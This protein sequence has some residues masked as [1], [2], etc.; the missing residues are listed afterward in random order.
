[1]RQKPRRNR[2]K[3]YITIAPAVKKRTKA[4]ANTLGISASRLIEDSLKFYME[5][6]FGV[7]SDPTA[8]EISREIEKLESR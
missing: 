1:M 2:E 8:E 5:K 4:L 7:R 3:L 6:K